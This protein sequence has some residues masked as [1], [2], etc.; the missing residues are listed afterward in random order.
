MMPRGQRLSDVQESLKLPL[1]KRCRSALWPAVMC[2]ILASAACETTDSALQQSGKSEAFITG[3]HDG[4]HSGMKEAGNYLEHMVK[5]FERFEKDPEY[6]AG[7]L[8]GEQEGMRIQNQA[9]AA[10]GA[11]AGYQI[12]RDA[13]ESTEQDI[14]KAGRKATENVDTDLLKGLK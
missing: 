11:A 6:R 1:T 4:R 7:W 2:L 8:A 10:V 14:S 5:D 12:T 9:N 3:F 13:E